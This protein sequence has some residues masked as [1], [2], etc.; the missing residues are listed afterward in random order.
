M[1]I[2]T[3]ETKVMKIFN[4]REKLRSRT[5]FSDVLEWFAWAS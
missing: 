5:P 3:T 2:S 4:V 1:R